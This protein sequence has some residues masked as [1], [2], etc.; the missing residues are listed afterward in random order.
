MRNLLPNQA[1]YSKV[2][3]DTVYRQYK[4]M[5]YGITSCKSTDLDLAT[6]RKH[7]VDWQEHE[8]AG[9]L[10]ETSIQYQTWLALNYDDVVYSQGGTGYIHTSAT[11]PTVGLNYVSGN[12]N[13]NIIQISAG[14]C[15]TRINLNPSIFI[16]ENTS[17]V[18]TQTTPATTWTITHNLNMVPN[19]RTEDLTGQ[20]IEGTIEV[21]NENQ[22]KITFSQPVSGK[23]YLS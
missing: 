15:I 9:A 7:I 1:K 23:A 2:F 19:V 10:D 11:A 5:R 4:Q 16:A 13:E 18:H 21:V 8:D 12:I 20:D 17:Y 3:A 6:M 22:I 14:G